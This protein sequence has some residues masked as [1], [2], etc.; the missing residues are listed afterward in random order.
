MFITCWTYALSL[1]VEHV[2]IQLCLELT[3][4]SSTNCTW[5][6]LSVLIMWR[7]QLITVELVHTDKVQSL[8]DSLAKERELRL[9]AEQRAQDVSLQVDVLS[10]YFNEKEKEFDRYLQ[11]FTLLFLLLSLNGMFRR[12]GQEFCYISFR[13]VKS[14]P[15]VSNKCDEFLLHSSTPCLRKKSI[16]VFVRTIKFLPILINCGRKMAKWLKLYA[17]YTFSISPNLCHRTTLLNTDVPNC[18]I[19]LEFNTIIRL[20]VWHPSVERP[21]TD[22]LNVDLVRRSGFCWRSSFGYPGGHKND[23]SVSWSGQ[24]RWIA[25]HQ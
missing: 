2:S 7:L 17:T 22:L 12:S 24:Q 13:T 8:T 9:S 19:T 10:S 1:L 3:S 14:A 16:F 6:M 18:Y 25:F 4:P 23:R 21:P 15:L 11:L 5:N 20:W